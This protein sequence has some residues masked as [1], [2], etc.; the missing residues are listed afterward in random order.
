MPQNTAFQ[1]LYQTPSGKL[2]PIQGGD[3]Y[4]VNATTGSDSNIGSLTHPFATLGAALAAATANNGDIIYLMGTVHLT[5]TL[6]WN[7]NGVSLVGQLSPSGNCRSRISS[8]GAT[9]FSP[10]VNVTGVG[11]SFINLG[12]FHGGFTGA[13]GSQVCWNEAAGRNYYSHVQFLGGGDATTAA[14]A[15]MRSLTIT[16]GGENV[17][18]DCTVGLDTIVRATNANASMELLSSTPRN[19]MNRPIFRALIS[20]TAD[21]HITVGVDGMDRDLTLNN[22]VFLNAV[23][24]TGSTMAAAITNNAASGGA[25]VLNSPCSVG[26]TALATTGNVYVLSPVP[27]AATSGIA[28]LA[29]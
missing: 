9:A 4:Y 6:A 21:V 14:L 24:S 7:K 5:A 17:F 19:V 11:C 2:F 25:I 22:P 8:T 16:G 15:G 20:D 27:T 3:I 29:T 28:I 26:A 10:L 23:Y 18:D 13:T 1:A 12:T